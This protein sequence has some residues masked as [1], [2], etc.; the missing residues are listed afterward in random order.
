MGR[1]HVTRVI[2][3]VNRGELE[4]TLRRTTDLAPF[5]QVVVFT[6]MPGGEAVADSLDFPVDLCLNNKVPP[7]ACVA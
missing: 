1:R 5:A 2:P 7:P 6:L 4:L 3:S